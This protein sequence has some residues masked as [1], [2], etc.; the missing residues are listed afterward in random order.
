MEEA[1]SDEEKEVPNQGDATSI[2]FMVG[3]HGWL[4]SLHGCYIW[5][6]LKIGYIPNEI[7]IFHRDNDH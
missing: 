5:G 2:R 6:C 4:P 1:E 7:A 3:L